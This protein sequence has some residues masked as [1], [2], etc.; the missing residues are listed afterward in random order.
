M[1]GGYWPG[2]Q[3]FATARDGG[4]GRIVPAEAV[5]YKG[6]TYGVLFLLS[7]RPPPPRPIKAT[8]LRAL[9]GGGC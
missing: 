9:A 1:T 7:K 5:C 6:Q 2:A 3:D 8:C 4:P